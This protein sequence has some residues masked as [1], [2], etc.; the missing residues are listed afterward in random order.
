MVFLGVAVGISAAPRIRFDARLKG[1]NA[2][3]LPVDTNA[4]G[5]AKVEIVDHRQAIYLQIEIAGV[6][7]AVMAG[8]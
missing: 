6:E 8:I 7:G 3:G 5:Q 1:C 2:A 4:T